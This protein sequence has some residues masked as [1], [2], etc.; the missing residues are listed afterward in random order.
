MKAYPHNAS[1]HRGHDS[2]GPATR[3]NVVTGFSFLRVEPTRVSVH[4]TW[5]G[6]R[7]GA[8][9]MV[10]SQEVY[11]VYFTKRKTFKFV[12]LEPG[13]TYHVF[14]LAVEQGTKFIAFAEFET[15]V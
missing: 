10:F 2:G 14:V 3:E 13:T 9:Y 1:H 5:T 4:L 11:G 6:P 7:D 8:R 12:G 15:L